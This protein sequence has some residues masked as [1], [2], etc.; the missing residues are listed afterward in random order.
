L[1]QLEELFRRTV[2][3]LSISTDGLA[4]DVGVNPKGDHVKRCDSVA[5]RAALNYLQNDFPWPVRV[6]SEEAEPLDIGPGPPQYTAII[7]PVDG[8]D[9]FCRGIPLSGFAVALNAADEPV[10][11]ANVQYALVGD[12]A[13]GRCWKAARGNGTFFDG[14]RL[15]PAAEDRAER[16]GE[17]MISC[18]L[19]HFAPTPALAH[20]FERARGVRSFGCA[21]QAITMVATGAVDAHLDLR[22][23][24]T[25]ENFLAP[26]LILTEAGGTV[27]DPTGA[28]LPTVESLTQRF[29]LIAAANQELHSELVQAINEKKT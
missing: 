21:T 4:D 18:E 11:V 22:G 14:K 5:N 17:A 9:N 23:R 3:E 15:S 27:T 20:L 12:L 16:I 1:K 19:N 25:P 7:D 6:L 2:R 24:L 26:S 28:P 10:S 29:S 13:T 8:T